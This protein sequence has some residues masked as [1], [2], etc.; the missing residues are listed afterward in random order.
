MTLIDL[1]RE[2]D[3]SLRHKGRAKPL[4]KNLGDGY[5]LTFNPIYRNIR[6]QARK[7]KF[8]F[9][10]KRFF[11]Y[12]AL[13]LTQ[14]PRILSTQTIPYVDT[15]SSLR[16]IE[17]LA[18]G[19]FSLDDIPPLT[20]NHLFH[21]SA[22]AAVHHLIQH[23]IPLTAKSGVQK[24]RQ[25]A[26]KIL[27]EEAF[28]NACESFANVYAHDEFHDEFLFKNTYIMENTQV[29]KLLKCAV[30]RFGEAVVFKIL[31]YSFLHANFQRIEAAMLN[32]PR[33]IRLAFEENAS[34]IKELRDV[35]LVLLRSTFKTGLD[36]DPEFTGFTNQ[37]CLRLNGIK[38]PLTQLFSYDFLAAFE[39]QNYKLCINSM[40]S[41]AI[42][43]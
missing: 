7:Q 31:L 2:H 20:T 27:L 9:S 4:A 36:L 37:F 11:N 13:S 29:R 8:K 43:S 17:H 18:P 16:E 3:R 33:V 1:L 35:D 23:N 19:V 21:E 40:T 41:L 39:F 24:E 26:F 15:V 12:D 10:D 14:L 30:K 22:H 32:L 28:A 5:L 25:I 42:G 34:A 38:T 6:L